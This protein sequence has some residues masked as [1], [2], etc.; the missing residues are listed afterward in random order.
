MK[1]IT[2][3]PPPSKPL[4]Q[5]QKTPYPSSPMETNTPNHGDVV[6]GNPHG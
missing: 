1:K 5:T 3:P 2:H 4:K 6:E